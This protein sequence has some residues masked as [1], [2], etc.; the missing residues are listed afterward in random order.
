MDIE[1]LSFFQEYYLDT[2]TLVIMLCGLFDESSKSH[3]LKQIAR[4]TPEDFKAVKMALRHAKQINV[5]P[6]VLTE[7]LALL[8]NRIPKNYFQPFF[9][10]VKEWLLATDEIFDWTKQGKNQLLTHQK[11]SDFGIVDLSLFLAPAGT[12]TVLV[13]S[14]KALHGM[15]K[16]NGVNSIHLSELVA[17]YLQQQ[18]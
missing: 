6:H 17:L 14:D 15:C 18:N 4:F 16:A 5:T 13:T 11:C 2:N 8:E 3:T 7:T 10:N 9:S 1:D 12:G